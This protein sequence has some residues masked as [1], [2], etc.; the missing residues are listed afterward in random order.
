MGGAWDEEDD[1]KQARPQPQLKRKATLRDRLSECEWQVKHE[2][3]ENQTT[4]D[5]LGELDQLQDQISERS[6][7][8]DPDMP[9]L[10]NVSTCTVTTSSSGSSLSGKTNET[11]DE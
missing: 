9:I 6:G 7:T 2:Q 1:A 4:L 8:S 10:S 11:D 5:L 3:L